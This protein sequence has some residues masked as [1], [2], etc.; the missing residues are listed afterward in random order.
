MLIVNFEIINKVLTFIFYETGSLTKILQL[1]L[2][3]LFSN[4]IFQIVSP[5]EIFTCH[6]E[7]VLFFV[8]YDYF[9]LQPTNL[10]TDFSI[11]KMLVIV[12]TGLRI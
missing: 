11:C 10:L 12:H 9:L 4:N 1:F 5:L 6:S 3:V 2:V 8:F 7:K